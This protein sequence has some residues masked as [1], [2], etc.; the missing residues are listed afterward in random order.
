MIKYTKLREHQCDE[1]ITFLTSIFGEKIQK[2]ASDY[3]RCMFSNDFRRPTFIVALSNN[4][5]IGSAVYSEELF[6]IDT[7]G[8][9]WVAVRQQHRNQE[10]GRNLI[11]ACIESIKKRI[12]KDCSIILRTYPDKTGLYDKNGFIKMGLD[13]ED[14]HY[15]IKHI[16]KDGLQNE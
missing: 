12:E 9:S 2:L 5:I 10:I 13:H 11:K 1:V 8:I 4:E 6:T 15:M 3:V 7:W 14:G 16:E